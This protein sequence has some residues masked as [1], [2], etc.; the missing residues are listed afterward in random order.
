M[1]ILIQQALPCSWISLII[2]SLAFSASGSGK[3]QLYS[4]AKYTTLFRGEYKSLLTA[5]TK[6]GYEFIANSL[7][8]VFVHFKKGLY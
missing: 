3:R 6:R 2:L 8:Q 1:E 5:F 4:N 7:Y